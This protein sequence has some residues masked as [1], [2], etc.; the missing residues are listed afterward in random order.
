MS[1]D[2]AGAAAGGVARLAADLE[3]VIEAEVGARLVEDGPAAET[4]EGG[5][6]GHVGDQAVAVEL[7]HGAALPLHRDGP[8]RGQHEHRA[9]VRDLGGPV[10]RL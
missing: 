10:H 6:A 8:T 2:H 1:H 3:L 4:L 5:K 9:R 7:R